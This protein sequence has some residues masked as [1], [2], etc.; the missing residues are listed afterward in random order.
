MPRCRI[1][2]LLCVLALVLFAARTG[3]AQ[4]I[5]RIDSLFAR[6]DSDTTPG[7]AVGVARDGH[8]PIL[9]SYG[10]ASLEYH[11]AL[12]PTMRFDAASMAKQFTASAIVLLADQGKLR[13]DDDVRRYVPELP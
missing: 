8:A 2:R 11:V 13:L 4:E 7:C 6:F 10:M 5:A 1:H 3:T 12:T 9:R